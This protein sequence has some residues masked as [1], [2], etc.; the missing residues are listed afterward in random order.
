MKLC[1][2]FSWKG[3]IAAHFRDSAAFAILK[4]AIFL[5][6]VSNWLVFHY[7]QNKG[8]IAFC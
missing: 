5:L 8:A 6:F 7:V 3:G 1:F 4:S 2:I